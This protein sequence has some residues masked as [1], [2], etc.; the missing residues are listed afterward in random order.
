MSTQG[1]QQIQKQSQSMVLAPQLRQSLK[2]LQA[3]TMELRSSI[4][5]E[6]QIN[7]TLEELPMEGVSLDEP[8]SDNGD[9]G[10]PDGEMDFEKEDFE[11]L[12]RLDES[13]RDSIGGDSAPR[14]TT[15]DDEERRKHFFDS[16][17]GEVSLQEHLFSQ[18]DLADMDG[19]DRKALEYLIGSLDRD[20]FLNDEVGNIALSADLPLTKVKAM[21]ELLLSLDPVGIGAV[22][23]RECLLV[24]LEFS[25]KEKSLAARILRDH[26]PLL[27]RRRI[28][29]LARKF[30]VD[31]ETI[32]RALEE[33]GTLDPSP[34]RRFAEDNNRVIV[35]DVKV[36]CDEE[37]RW[38][39]VLNND[40]IPRLRISRLYKELIA[41][42][43][44]PQKDRDYLRE[45]IRS[46]R[47][48]MN[49]IEQRQQ[50][51]ERIARQLVDLQREFFESGVSRLKPLTMSRVADIIEVHETT[52][53]RAIANKYIDTP[54]GI[55]P[56]KYFFTAG[57]RTEKGESVSSRSVKDTIQ[58]LVENEDP[59]KPYSDQAIVEILKEK[60]FRIARR[61]VA[62]YREEL[63]IL[64]TNLRREYQ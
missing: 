21:R 48:L 10:E 64:A 24:Q 38:Q 35:P 13:W 12:N 53:S 43:R 52:V 57:Y 40:Y 26:Y 42:G 39:V 32:H 3:P 25:G 14:T 28:P 1:F 31:T 19:G 46:G 56:L 5:E 49:S 47:F 30:G 16:F 61:T 27:L 6:L 54:H 17:V 37:G 63:G 23:R 7:P 4:L 11:I 60:G 45:K 58:Q 50:T 59:A 55:F 2:I 62:K 44:L 9:D 33:I 51:V 20:G 18:A 29:E 8:V 22:D 36:F 34:G 15:S 41:Q